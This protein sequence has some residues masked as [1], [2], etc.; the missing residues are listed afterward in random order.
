M[1]AQGEHSTMEQQGVWGGGGI[2]QEFCVQALGRYESCLL[3]DR[4]IILD[5]SLNLS[6]FICTMRTMIM[7]LQ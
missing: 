2:M 3:S 7:T 5:E 1:F 4:C 6:V